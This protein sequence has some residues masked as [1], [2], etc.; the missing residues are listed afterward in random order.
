MMRLNVTYAWTRDDRTMSTSE[1]TV[2]SYRKLFSCDL[3]MN[4]TSEQNSFRYDRT[5]GRG[6]INSSLS[7]GWVRPDHCFTSGRVKSV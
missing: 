2:L 7:V 4:D 6:S 1:L 3:C 5:V